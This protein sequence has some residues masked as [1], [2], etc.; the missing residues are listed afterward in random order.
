MCPNDMDI[1]VFTLIYEPSN[2]NKVRLKWLM[3]QKVE[4]NN[5][6]QRMWATLGYIITL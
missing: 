1:S 3:G 6:M 2:L 4:H 5:E